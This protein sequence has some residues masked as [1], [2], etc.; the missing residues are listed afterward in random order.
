V[1]EIRGKSGGKLH[2]SRLIYLLF[3]LGWM[4]MD[5]MSIKALIVVR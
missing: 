1:I 4:G 2:Y 3:L 5:A